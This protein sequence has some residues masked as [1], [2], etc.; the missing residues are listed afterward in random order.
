[1][2]IKHEIEP[3]SFTFPIRIIYSFEIQVLHL[4]LFQSVTVM[5]TL[6]DENNSP[7]DNK[8]I[9]ID[10]DDYL[11][12]SNNDNWLIDYVLNKLNLTKKI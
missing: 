5:I 11:N 2:N 7:I 3:A 8:M 9:T 4:V 10:G 6:Y 1:M 12:W